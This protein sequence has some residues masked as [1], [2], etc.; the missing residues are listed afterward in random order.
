[1]MQLQRAMTMLK[2]GE[3]VERAAGIRRLSQLLNHSSARDL[4]GRIASQ[5]EQVNQSVG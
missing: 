1:M 5:L 3:A 2:N 4:N